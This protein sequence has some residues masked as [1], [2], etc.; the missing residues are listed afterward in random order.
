MNYREFNERVYNYKHGIKTVADDQSNSI[1]HGAIGEGGDYIAHYELGQEADKHKYKE[2]IYLGEG[3]YR[4]IYDDG[5][6]STGYKPLD[7]NDPVRHKQRSQQTADTASD[8]G[9]FLK[10]NTQ[11]NTNPNYSNWN[12]NA[13]SQ[14]AQA[15]A[16]ATPSSKPIPYKAIADQQ[17]AGKAEE[18]KRKEASTIS[19]SYK[20][21][22]GIGDFIKENVQSPSNRD[23]TN[24]RKEAYDV[25]NKAK[26][27]QA[28]PSAKPITYKKAD[29]M[30]A[31][32]GGTGGETKPNTG[33]LGTKVA[34]DSMKSTSAPNY[35]SGLASNL[36]PTAL[37]DAAKTGNTEQTATGISD[38]L[39]E[40]VQNPTNPAV[41]VPQGAPYSELQKQ[42]V[43]TTRDSQAKKI[44]DDYMWQLEEDVYD[45]LKRAGWS[46]EQIWSVIDAMESS[47]AGEAISRQ[48]S[49]VSNDANVMFFPG[50]EEGLQ[51]YI[52]NVLPA[53][54]NVAASVAP[55]QNSTKVD[56]SVYDPDVKTFGD[57]HGKTA[58]DVMQAYKRGGVFEA[59]NAFLDSDQGKEFANAAKGIANNRGLSDDGIFDI[60][61]YK[62]FYGSSSIPDDWIQI[63][64]KPA[65]DAREYMSGDEYDDF[66]NQIEAILRSIVNDQGINDYYKNK[67]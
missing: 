31:L 67:N 41:P 54:K 50:A 25:E 20:T 44:V 51:V 15:K 63:L 32:Y 52:N 27:P 57:S 4:Y 62:S 7:A 48:L 35:G 11:T 53:L 19:E 60:N 66:S 26:A 13:A 16:N 42:S 65:S 33:A 24:A 10:T 64:F 9:N 30:A 46:E 37:P 1:E 22:S 18:E 59:V 40:N 45:P 29:E 21:A 12:A 58:A 5:T 6:S 8:I 14:E 39:K 55:A 49:N 43:N 61:T 38:F 47:L 23:F 36:A 34:P 3:K 28:A 17:A 2:K 56:T